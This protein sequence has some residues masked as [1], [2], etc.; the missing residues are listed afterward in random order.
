MVISAVGGDPTAVVQELTRVIMDC[1]GNIKESRMG[2]FGSEFAMLL[3]VAGNWH[4]ISRMERELNRFA[5]NNGVT[6]QLSAPSRAASARS[7]CPTPSTSSDSISPAS[8]T[9]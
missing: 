3:L 5:N 8:C 9:A 2:A 7:C 4:T 6:M 1:G